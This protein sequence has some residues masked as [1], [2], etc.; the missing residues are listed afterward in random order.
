[1][2]LRIIAQGRLCECLKSE[3]KTLEIDMFMR[4][5]GLA[6]DAEKDT[7]NLTPQARS[8]AEAYAD[9]VNTHLLRHRLPLEFA[10]VGHKPE[11]W[12]VADTLLTTKIM[13]YVGLAQTQ[14]DMEKLIIQAIQQ[15]VSVEKL[16]V[17]LA[18]HLEGLDA[19]MVNVIKQLRIERPLVPESIRFLGALPSVTASNNWA[20]AG[21][22]TASGHPMECHDPHLEVNRLPAIWYEAVMHTPDDYRIGVTMPGV[23]GVI[24]G[25]TRR[26]S[27]GFTYGFMDMIDYFVEEC[28][29]GG[30][31]RGEKIEPLEVRK[32]TIL[33]KKDTPVEITVR[34]TVHG[35]L[36]ADAKR[37]DLPDGLYLSR[38]WS[39]HRNGASGSLN[40]LEAILHVGTVTEAQEI[41]AGVSLS[42]NWVLAD[43][44]GHIGLQQ[45]GLLPDRKHSG[46]S[47]VPGWDSA[48]DWNGLVSPDQ[49]HR[50]TDPPEGVIATANDDINPP[51]G[52]LAVNLSMGSYRVERVR[53]LLAV[54]EPLT[55]EH[56][57]RIQLDLYSIQ[58][59]RF[60]GLFR[61]HL[62]ETPVGKLLHE[63][64]LCYDVESLGAPLFEKI[65][66]ALI[67]KVFGEGLF[68]LEAW[69]EI[70]AQTC[71]L[72]DYFHFFDDALLAEDSPWYADGG[73]ETILAD[74][75]RKTLDGID[76]ETLKPWGDHRK[77]TMTNIFFDGSL[78]HWMGFD[79][80]PVRL[81]GCRATIVQGA[82][83]EAHGR[84]TSFA[85][86]HRFVTDMGSH[87]AETVLPGG[88][89]GRR[90]SRLYRTGIQDWL[91]GRY[92]TLV[93]NPQ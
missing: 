36:E 93:G 83:F 53:S 31:R 24:L 26:V 58:A 60:M 8:L 66:H 92:K 38:A 40:A 4:D 67:R 37:T 45:S 41:L 17:L 75:V 91:D 65:Y 89:S 46:L 9:G 64:D 29:D 18:P 70:T 7:A 54:D 57:K 79:H 44:E 86:S 28:R 14:E 43:S 47:P 20:V 30:Y 33:R 11:P 51:G 34:E 76:A 61:P 10:L 52:P 82:I 39:A 21:S 6:R 12:R 88:P 73:R 84:T 87:R 71:I 63:W 48:F 81:P 80:G 68:G 5:L 35:V 69:N 22:R 78:P 49:L 2:F 32:E 90:T 1:M 77:L 59:E 55:L 16:K 50:I 62:P 3:D 19:E 23:P 74:V 25:R 15:G 42:C 27:F 85:P 72:N 13:S 56:M